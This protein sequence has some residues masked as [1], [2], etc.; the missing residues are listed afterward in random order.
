MK[1]EDLLKIGIEQKA[2]DLH[3]LP[4]LPPLLRVFGDLTPIKDIPSLSPED[5][6]HCIY[7]IMTIPQQDALE[8]NLFVEF[9]I[10]FPGLGNFRVSAFHQNKGLAAVFRVIPGIPPSFDEL[11][12][13]RRF[14]ALLNLSYG[15]IIVTGATGSGK[16]T[17]LAAMIDYI[18]STR[19]CNIITIEDPIEYIHPNKK[20]AINQLQVGRDTRSMK[21]ALRASLRQDPDVILVGEM[22]DLETIRLALT[23]AE[24]GHLV[25]TT[26]HASSAPL[27]ISRMVDVFPRAEQNRVRNILS[28]S[29]QAVIYQTLVKKVSGGRVAAFEVMIATPGI[30]HLIRQDMASHMESAIQTGSEHGMC[31]LEQYYQEL[32]NKNLITATTARSLVA[33]KGSF[34]T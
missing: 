5:V 27:S 11:A 30:R 12:L 29:L 26:L 28:E 15:L 6:K 18:N 31:T 22:R 7:D 23:A 16:S 33:K 1:A 34:N 19:S 13:P 2:S 4:E 10:E 9:A 14:Q 25:L 20:S 21:S 3:L 24:T 17:T 32:L 8:S